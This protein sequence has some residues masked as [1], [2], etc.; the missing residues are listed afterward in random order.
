[1][2]RFHSISSQRT[3]LLIGLLIGLFV[4]TQTSINSSED[5]AKDNQ[6]ESNHSSTTE[7]TK[8]SEAITSSGLQINLGFQS[9][10]LQELVLDTRG[11]DTKSSLEVLVASIEEVLKVLLR[12]IIS[13]NA[14]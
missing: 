2:K 7:Q 6:E 12:R 4:L 5:I 11:V 9:F 13:P 3:Q 10:L 1:M 8:V 14:P